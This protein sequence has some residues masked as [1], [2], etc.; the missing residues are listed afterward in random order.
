M[1]VVVTQ[2]IIESTGLSEAELQ[3]LL[4]IFQLVDLDHGGTISTEELATLM[5][6]M[7]IRSTKVEIETMLNEIDAGDAGEI[8]FG[9]FVKAMSRKVQTKTSRENLNL[10]FRRWSGEGNTLTLGEIKQILTK[11]GNKGKLLSVDEA[12]DLIN[13]VIPQAKRGS[14]DWVKFL[15]TVL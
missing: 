6:T 2:S 12:D 4:E 14:L 1:Q 13:A 7:G 15:N 8:D 10:A 5:Q 3:E 9:T 11:Y